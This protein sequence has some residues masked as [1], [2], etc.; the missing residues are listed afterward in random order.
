MLDFLSW[1]L[2]EINNEI[3]ERG[4]SQR[5]VQVREAIE[6]YLMEHKKERLDV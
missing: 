3:E 2:D 4:L 1:L 6:S 5:L